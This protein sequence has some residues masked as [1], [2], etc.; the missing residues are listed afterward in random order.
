MAGDPSLEPNRSLSLASPEQAQVDSNKPPTSEHFNDDTFCAH[1]SV[2]RLRELRLMKFC[3][4][5]AV[6]LPS[7]ESV[8]RCNESL[9]ELG[10]SLPS[11]PSSS[12]SSSTSISSSSSEASPPLSPL[13]KTEPVSSTPGHTSSPLPSSTSASS[14]LMKSDLPEMAYYIPLS[15]ID[16]TKLAYLLHRL[17]QVRCLYSFN[18]GDVN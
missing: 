12:Y 14:L 11:T 3:P 17:S 18:P 6:P 9:F 5:E 7:S 2:E 4:A 10:S 15:E 8:L 1:P 16:S 13:L